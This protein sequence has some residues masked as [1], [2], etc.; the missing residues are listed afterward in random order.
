MITTKRYKISDNKLTVYLFGC[1]GR[2]EKCEFRDPNFVINK[3]DQSDRLKSI[4]L[5]LTNMSKKFDKIFIE[6]RGG[7][8]GLQDMEVLNWLDSVSDKVQ[9]PVD[10]TVHTNGTVDLT[11]FIE[12]ANLYQFLNKPGNNIQL[13]FHYF[14]EEEDL[15]LNDM[16]LKLSDNM[17][18]NFNR[19]NF[20]NEPV[21]SYRFICHG[22]RGKKE[23]EIYKEAIKQGY[24]MEWIEDDE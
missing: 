15:Y 5:E 1:N 6:I 9:C 14:T 19:P 24:K 13:I 4:E 3:K 17:P 23:E 11:D 22:T 8:P 18:L 7:E 2:C 16:S 20:L 10:V 12:L 21:L